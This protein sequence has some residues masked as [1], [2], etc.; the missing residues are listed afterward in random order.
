MSKTIFDY[1]TDRIEYPDDVAENPLPVG[2]LW[3]YVSHI[4]LNGFINYVKPVKWYVLDRYE[5]EGDTISSIPV[6]DKGAP[7]WKK[8]SGTKKELISVL[9]SGEKEAYH[10]N[11]GNFSDDVLLLAESEQRNK[12]KFSNRYFFF[13]FDCDVSDCFIGQFET[14]D[15]KEQVIK[16]FDNTLEYLKGIDTIT[17]YT[18]MKNGIL[19]G[20]ISF[21]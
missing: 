21:R 12:D 5:E 1:F 14:A 11:L 16:S 20:W 17:G 8:W 10:F 2:T 4:I 15:S 3:E 9:N 6:Q 7:G 19:K 13:W 18:E